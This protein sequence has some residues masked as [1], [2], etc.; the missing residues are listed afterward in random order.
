MPP[1]PPARLRCEYLAEPLGVDTPSPRLSWTVESPVR[2]DRSKAFHVLVSSS[3]GLLR[4]DIGDFLD[5]GLTEADGASSLE[6]RGESLLSCARYFWKVRWRDRQGRVSAWSEP[7]SFVT[8]FLNPGDWKPKWIAARNVTEF[9]SKGTVLLGHAGADDTQACAVYLRREF[10]LK[11]RPS[12]AMIFI[13]G[14]GH[15]ELRLN[16][17]KVGT[18]VLDPGWT[19]YGKKALYASH[20][21]TGLVRDKNAVGVILG[22]G[23]HTRSYGYDT[24]KL[25]CR[26]EVEYESG[27]RDIFFSDESWKTSGGPLQENGLYFGERHDARIL[28]DGWDQP[29]FDDRSW[30]KA[31]PSAGGPLVSQMMPPVRVTETL[32]PKSVRCLPVRGLDLRLRPE[33]L[34]LDAPQGRGPD[35]RRGPPST[36]GAPQRGRHPQ[37]RAERERRGHGR[38][39]PP[40]R[41]AR[42]LRAEVHLSRLP[43]RRDDRVPGRARSGHPRGPVRPLG[44]RTDRRVPLLQR[45]HR[46]HPSERRLGAAL[47]LHEHPHRL[48]AAR[49]APRLARRRPPFGRGSRLQFRRGGLLREVPRRHPAGPKGGREPAR[50]RPALSLPPLPCRPGLELGLCDARRASL[51]P[52]R[53]PPRRRRPLCEPKEVHRLPRPQ[54]RPRHHPLARQVRRLVP[55]RRHRAQEDARGTDVHLVLLP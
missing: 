40:R 35:G 25:T 23:R 26:V 49:R 16:G 14:L 24:P 50:R 28:I 19:D 38:L 42:G 3:P 1:S 45:A 21:V 43:I 15:Y 2:G 41:R 7:G 12:L 32:A 46:P 30:D 20:E 53:R 31:V 36:R 29:G 11:E 51:G 10:A 34:R 13:S 27:E 48:P 47:E 4:G 6:Y 33:F 18:S 54:R 37:P 39:H 44:R 22:N 5:T 8:G 55:A 9:R 17:K 52:L